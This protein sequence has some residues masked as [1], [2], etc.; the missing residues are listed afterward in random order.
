MVGDAGLDR[1]SPHAIT[2]M[3][4]TNAKTLLGMVPN[5]VINEIAMAASNVATTRSRELRIV[6]L[7]YEES[8]L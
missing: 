2:P 7:N 3:D 4:A 8:D 6:A 5:R 1:L